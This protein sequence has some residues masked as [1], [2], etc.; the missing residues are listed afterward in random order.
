MASVMMISS[1]PNTNQKSFLIGKR[2]DSKNL[3]MLKDYLRDD[4]SSCSSN[5][6][7]SFPRKQCCTTVRFLLEIDLNN[8]NANSKQLQKFARSKSSSGKSASSA[9]SALQKAVVNAVKLLPFPS[10][11]SSSKSPSP[12][13]L[14]PR[15]FSRRI[16]KKSFWKKVE[17]RKRADGG[18]D[19]CNDG[20]EITRRRLF[21]EFLEEND[22]NNI[23]STHQHHSTSS[24]SNSKSSSWSE[25]EFSGNSESYSS[26]TSKNG[27]VL[28]DEKVL[29]SGQKVSD[30]VGVTIAKEWAN[31]EEEKEQFSPVSVL[32]CP[33]QD[34]E[35]ESNS[36]PFQRKLDRMEGGKQKLAAKT[37]SFESVA[38]VEPVKLEKR[39]E[40]AGLEDNYDLVKSPIQTSS[41]SAVDVK[42]EKAQQLVNLIK[43]TT[44]PS[45][46]LTFKANDGLLLDFFREKSVEKNIGMVKE[47][48]EIKE[49]FKQE[50][51]IVKDWINGHPQ[52]MFLGWEVKDNRLVYIKD[53]ERSAEWRN[54]NE[55]QEE[56]ILELELAVFT[57][58]VNEVLL[59]VLC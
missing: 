11:S 47:E 18:T 28:S 5:G 20:G 37:R 1:T 25:S 57:D 10:S 48:E 58:L 16:F 33:Y 41:M 46:S 36:S 8:T 15:S 13:K 6:F 52:D 51:E 2:H 4:F 22:H 30:G 38:Q 56:L 23:Q 27:V 19:G 49:L 31:E 7:K 3:M 50:L 44:T 39:I 54:L 53:M 45:N 17:H 59:D 42:E 9:I 55:E 34:D 21:H 14:L 29:P 24:S 32:D 12:S 40:L 26:S 43:T 35:E